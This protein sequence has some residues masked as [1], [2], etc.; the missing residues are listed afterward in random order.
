MKD[1]PEL[2][3]CLEEIDKIATIEFKK[4]FLNYYNDVR[5]RKLGWLDFSSDDEK[6]WSDLEELMYK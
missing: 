5:K 3:S 6:M 4:M 2:G 1:S